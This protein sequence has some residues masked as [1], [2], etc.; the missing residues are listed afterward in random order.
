MK[1]SFNTYANLLLVVILLSTFNACQNKEG[2]SASEGNNI[3][4]RTIKWKSE[5]DFQIKDIVKETQY[6]PLEDTENSLFSAIDKLIIK[7]DRIYLL[8]IT[9]P[10]SLLVFDIT[11]KFLHRVGRQGNG[12]GEYAHFINFDVLDNGIVSLYDQ[13]KRRMMIYDADGNYI[14]S[15]KSSYSFNDFCRLSDNYYLLALDV[16][17]KNNNKRKISLTK[18]LKH[19]EKSYF[20]FSDDYKNDRQ[21]TR[22]FQPYKDDIAYML[23]VA[24]DTL[25][26]FDRQGTIQQTYFFDFG[27]QKL[28]EKLKNSYEEI[29]NKRR[30]GVYYTYVFNTPILIR[31]YI[32]AI[33]F[34][35]NQKYIAV[36][37]RVNNTST[38]EALTPENF[39]TEHVNFPLY[40]INDSIIISYI[41]L[42]LMR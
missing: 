11:G 39:S 3:P 8:D 37:D 21:N 19:V 33:I 36:F 41:D 18:D 38:Y 40:A 32:F 15:I 10:K 9:G 5:K 14:Q 2:A 20:Y 28:P 6:I 31:D 29:I 24:S 23:P 1:R 25:F 35:E 4:T 22:V 27:N 42:L 17:E 13:S 30:Q 16:Y 26:I 34:M 12:P 7:G